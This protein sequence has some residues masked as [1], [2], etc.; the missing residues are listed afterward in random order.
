[1]SVVSEHTGVASCMYEGTV[2]HWR[3]RPEREFQHRIAMAYV[4]LDELPALLG[5]RLLRRRPGI[6][7]FRRSDYHGDQRFQLNSVVRD[8]VAQ[9]TGRRPN[10][11]IRVL[12]T[13]RSYGL[14]FN[15]VSFYYCFD[16]TGTQV[17]AV[18]AEVTNTPWGERHAYVIPGE[19]GNFEK[20]MHVS[21]FM[22]MDHVYSCRAPVPGSD[23]RVVIENHRG[24]EKLFEAALALHRVELTAA[25]MRR[26]SLRYPLATLRT[27]ALIYGHAVG[28]RVAGVRPFPHPPRTSA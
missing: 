11:P 20:A 13:L 21:P 24:G 28:L 12:T 15:P 7:R 27:L 9:H 16:Q 26:I 14:C 8:T 6:V 5:G 3:L 1:M 22:A 2:S 18:L 10:G 23:L 17:E 25:S 19:V 4:D